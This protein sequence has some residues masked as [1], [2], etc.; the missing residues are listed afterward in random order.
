MR[1]PPGDVTLELTVA[2]GLLPSGMSRTA[3]SVPDAQLD[4]GLT[5]DAVVSL[6]HVKHLPTPT[7]SPPHSPST[8]T[9]SV[10]PPGHS[11]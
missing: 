8:I 3:V 10:S 4:R 2:C 6:E 11:F 5:S 9:T 1:L 7:P